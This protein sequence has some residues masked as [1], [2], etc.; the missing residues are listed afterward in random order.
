MEATARTTWAARA[1]GLLAVGLLV[2][3]WSLTSVD[4]GSDVFISALVVVFSAVG[5]LVAGRHPANATGWLFLG[6]GVATGLGTLAGSYADAWVTGGYDGSRRLG[7]AAAWYGTLSWIPFILV[8]CTFV[9]LLFPDGHL[10]SPR[11]RG[12]PGAPAPG[13]R[14]SSSPSAFTPARSRTTRTSTTPTG[15]TARCSLR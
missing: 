1:L 8:P 10:L 13:W 6:V 12:S 7:E 2:A 4:L 14:A 3:C 9:L 11:W 5:V 15:P